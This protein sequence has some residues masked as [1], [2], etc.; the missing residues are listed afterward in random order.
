MINKST[1]FNESCR[2]FEAEREALCQ[3][4]KEMLPS[5]L[6][7]S[8]EFKQ[9]TNNVTGEE[10]RWFHRIR[11]CSPQKSRFSI[12]YWSKS[13]FSFFHF[14]VLK[15]YRDGPNTF[16]CLSSGIP[17]RIGHKYHSHYHWFIYSTKEKY[18]C[19][20]LLLKRWRDKLKNVEGK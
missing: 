12:G 11:L 16:N 7:K 8:Q 4:L 6:S 9:I 14:R 18:Q 20:I 10:H 17:V 13:S 3:V 1:S 15:K 2:E 19:S 5:A